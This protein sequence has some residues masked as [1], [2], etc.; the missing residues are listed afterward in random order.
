MERS[1]SPR[2]PA[3]DPAAEKAEQPKRAATGEPASGDERRAADNAAPN[4]ADPFVEAEPE[5]TLAKAA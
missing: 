4:A 1:D 2:P 3:A 5:A